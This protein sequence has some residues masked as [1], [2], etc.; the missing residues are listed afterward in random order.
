[1]SIVFLLTATLACKAPPNKTTQTLYVDGELFSL[2]LN[3]VSPDDQTTLFQEIN[4]LNLVINQG[5][6]DSSSHM[7][8]GHAGEGIADNSVIP[9]LQDA[10]LTIVGGHNGELVFHGTSHPVTLTEGSSVVSIFI[11]RNSATTGLSPLNEPR[12]FSPL[13]A[14]GNGRFYSF[15][16]SSL[17]TQEIESS[18]FITRLDLSHPEEGLA[19]ILLSAKLPSQP[20]G[21]GWLAQTANLIGG[22]SSHAGQVLIAGGAPVFPSNE[23]TE[24]GN[25]FPSKNSFRFDPATEMLHG[26]SPMNHA[27]VDHR[28]ATNH[29]GEVVV[30]GGF[31]VDGKP[32]GKIDVYKPESEAWDTQ[33]QQMQ[34]GVV[35]HAMA[36]WA[37]QGVLVCGGL[38]TFPEYTYSDQCELIHSGV[39]EARAGMTMESA[40]LFTDMVTLADGR[41]LRTG[42]LDPTDTEHTSFRPG[43]MQAT[44]R[45]AIFHAGQW[46]EVEPMKNARAMHRSVLLPGGRVLIVGGVSG[47][48]PEAAREG[49][50]NGLLYDH[51]RAIACGE[52]FDPDTKTFSELDACGPISTNATLPERTLLPSV[53]VDP[54][55]G[56]V[57]AGGVGIDQGT[58]VDGVVLFHPAYVSSNQ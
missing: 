35:F 31:G 24:V 53:A 21:G 25:V 4:E 13:V 37:D 38:T 29:K 10:Q 17:G 8:S 41:V 14:T 26:A 7:L 46:D 18:T 44:D 55:Y 50:D 34:A 27:R 6:G 28:S 32:V 52:V 51:A 47:I 56:A 58:S 36:R 22:S 54:I 2:D 11:A 30:T 45:A 5:T 9:P 40:L 15:G 23:D 43:A 42:G 33:S 12:S 3:V 49:T 1:M 48:D 19:P 57:I 39:I 16:G 20:N